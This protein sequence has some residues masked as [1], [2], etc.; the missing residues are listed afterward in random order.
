[1]RILIDNKLN[2]D[3]KTSNDYRTI[4]GKDYSVLKYGCAFLNQKY[5]SDAIMQP[6]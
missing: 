5:V 4:E 2:K 1:M 3:E 6:S